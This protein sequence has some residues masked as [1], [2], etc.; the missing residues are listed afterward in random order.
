[1]S[2]FRKKIKS[3]IFGTDTTTSKLF[4]I[5]LIFLIILSVIVVLLDSV[6][7]IQSKYKIY[8]N[9]AEI[10]FTVIFYN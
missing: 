3:V 6:S 8:L 1:M 2:K 7:D 9:S 10:F 5:I 4:D